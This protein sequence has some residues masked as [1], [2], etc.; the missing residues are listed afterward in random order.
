VSTAFGENLKANLEKGFISK[1]KM[2]A[3]KTPT[4]KAKGLWQKSL[5]ASAA[6]VAAEAEA[7][8]GGEG[9]GQGA[10]KKRAKAASM[11]MQAVNAMAHLDGNLPMIKWWKC[12]K[13][14]TL[15]TSLHPLQ[16]VLALVCWGWLCFINRLAPFGLIASSVYIYSA[17]L[18]IRVVLVL[19]IYKANKTASQHTMWRRGMQLG[20]R[21]I[22]VNLERVQAWY[23]IALACDLLLV[24]AYAGWSATIVFGLQGVEPPEGGSWMAALGWSGAGLL[25]QLSMVPTFGFLLFRMGKALDWTRDPDT[26]EDQN[27]LPG[28]RPVRVDE[29][30]EEVNVAANVIAAGRAVRLIKREERASEIDAMTGRGHSRGASRLGGRSS[31]R[32]LGGASSRDVSRSRI[33][34]GRDSRRSRFAAGEEGWVEQ[35]RSDSMDGPGPQS[36]WASAGGALMRAARKSNVAFDDDGFDNGG[37]RPPSQWNSRTG[38]RRGSRYGRGSEIKGSG[39]EQTRELVEKARQGGRLST[40]DMTMLATAVHRTFVSSKRMSRA[41]FASGVNGEGGD[42]GRGRERTPSAPGVGASPVRRGRSK[43]RFAADGD[44]LDHAVRAQPAPGVQF[45]SSLAMSSLAPDVTRMLVAAGLNGNERVIQALAENGAD[46]RSFQ[47]LS[48]KG[49]LSQ[50]LED[51]GLGRMLQSK[52]ELAIMEALGSGGG[53]GL[54]RMGSRRNTGMTGATTPGSGK[55][56]DPRRRM[57]SGIGVWAGHQSTQQSHL[58]STG[59]HSGPDFAVGEGSGEMHRVAQALKALGGGSQM[60]PPH[61]RRPSAVSEAVALPSASEHAP[62]AAPAPEL[63]MVTMDDGTVRWLRKTATK[64]DLSAAESEFIVV[65]GK[66]YRRK[67]KRGSSQVAPSGFS[68][69][70]Q[71]ARPSG[72]EA[73]PTSAPRADGSRGEWADAGGM[74]QGTGASGLYPGERKPSGAQAPPP[75]HMEAAEPPRRTAGGAMA[76]PPMDDYG[77]DYG[78][79]R[80]GAMAPPPLLGGGGPPPLP[81]PGPGAP[82]YEAS[83]PTRGQM[84]RDPGIAPRALHFTPDAGVNASPGAPHTN[85]TASGIDLDVPPSR[86]SISSLVAMAHPAFRQHRESDRVELERKLSSERLYL[87]EPSDEKLMMG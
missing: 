47:H 46:M 14:L 57:D 61:P 9:A 30:G 60:P 52:L 53:H 56:H 3:K 29:E 50:A 74:P 37:G 73:D 62:G 51:L 17:I 55:L 64:R 58:G 11:M 72:R 5:M 12:R 43:S 85:A 13:T 8:E 32:A 31:G 23:G 49:E 34:V 81:P 40:K 41:R 70:A 10:R 65:D 83:T 19:L 76:P 6:A 75:R 22:E 69:F 25:L 28:M 84:A 39:A 71:T 27:N 7:E 36:H 16:N 80:G 20:R 38:S 86:G 79:T 48:E 68:S 24:M 42:D 33:M 54:S 66:R 44:E 78:R 1:K 77:Q 63:K 21:Q 87:G 18:A 45:A 82:S 67:N 15:L 26:I 4:I 35:S 2:D 59:G